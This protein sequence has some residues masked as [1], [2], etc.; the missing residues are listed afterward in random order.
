MKNVYMLVPIGVAALTAC[1]EGPSQ[2]TAPGVAL[3]AVSASMVG[4]VTM[5]VAEAS[6]VRQ[7]ENT[8]PTA[9]WVLY[10]RTGTAPSAAQFVPEQPH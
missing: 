7:T 8:T 9:S 1:A 5:I 10:T 2:P 4:D 6:V 3:S